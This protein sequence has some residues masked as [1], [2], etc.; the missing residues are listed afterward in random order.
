[1]AVALLVLLWVKARGEGTGFVVMLLA[2]AI[3]FVAFALY[4]VWRASCC[5]PRNGTAP[6]DA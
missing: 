3:G 5:A 2:A 1:M 6:T 4:C